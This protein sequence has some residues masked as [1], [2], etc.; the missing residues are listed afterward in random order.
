MK[1][2]FVTCVELGLSC[3]EEIYNQGYCID[4]LITLKDDKAKNKSGRV[5]L[6]KFSKIHNVDLLKI[7]HINDDEVMLAIEKY[8]IDWLFVIGWSQIAS[9]TLLSKPKKGVIGMHPTL[10]PEGR[11]RASIPWAIIKGLDKTGVTM[12]KLDEGVDTGHIIDQIEIPLDE[13]MD[14]TTLYDKVANAHKQLMAR[15]II[16][17]HNGSEKLIAQDESKATVWEGRKPDDG[18]ID[19][20]GSVYDAARL[21]RATTKPY[22]GAFYEDSDGKKTIIWKAK[23]N[24]TYK[25]E[26][27]LEFY[28]GVLEILDSNKTYSD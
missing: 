13:S 22:P 8:D 9:H 5:Y 2:G 28:D 25:G 11:G 1:F 16:S 17:L 6:D 23:V 15:N 4:L 12:F 7:N 26:S 27:K 24:N 3:L 10:L 14:A 20:S 18:K 21:I 19:L